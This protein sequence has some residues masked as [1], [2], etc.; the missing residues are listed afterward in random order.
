MSERRCPKCGSVYPE[1]ARFCPRDGNMLV[2]AQSRASAAAT[3]SG[4]ETGVRTPRTP[5]GGLGRD[6]A[7]SLSGQILDTRYQV[8]KKLGEGGMSYVYLAREVA[9][10]AE[11]AIKVLSPKLATDRSSV[12]RLRREDRKSTRLN[13]SHSQISYAVFC[14]K[15]K[16]NHMTAIQTQHLAHATHTRHNGT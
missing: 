16:I 6:R 10:G 12:E 13:S 4:G 9:S 11:V 15:K 8:T 14:L 1:T 5:R 3:P 7:S 2:E